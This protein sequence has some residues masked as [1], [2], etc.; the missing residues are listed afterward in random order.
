[1]SSRHRS[2]VPAPPAERAVTYTVT[3]T[4]QHVQPWQSSPQQPSPPQQP[5]SRHSSLE[6]CGRPRV[7]GNDDR[8]QVTRASM[9]LI[10]YV[11]GRVYFVSSEQAAR[12]SASSRATALAA[13][14]HLEYIYVNQEFPYAGYFLDFG[15]LHVGQILAFRRTLQAKLEALEQNDHSHGRVCVLASPSPMHRANAV[16]V[17]ACWGMI[18]YGWSPAEAYAPFAHVLLP[19]FH[20]A[21]LRHDAF[22]LTVLQV[23][24][25]L[26]SAMRH[27]LFVPSG[28]DVDAYQQLASLEQGN[29]S[30]LC[31]KLLAFA[32]PDDSEEDRVASKAS[33]LK[34]PSTSKRRARG[35][36]VYQSSRFYAKRFNELG[37]KTVVRLSKKRYDD[38][39]FEDAGI[40]V[41]DLFFPDGTAPSMA[42]VRRFLS[43]CEQ[44]R[45]GAIA[46]HCKAGLGRT[47]TLI[48]CYL[49]Q[50]YEF[51]AEAAVGW[52]RLCRPGS[53]IGPQQHFLR[54]APEDVEI[55]FVA[56]PLPPVPRPVK[57]IAARKLQAV[58]PATTVAR[59]PLLGKIQPSWSETEWNVI[60]SSETEWNA[61]AT[62]LSAIETENVTIATETAAT[63]IEVI[64]AS[65][66]TAAIEV[67]ATE[68]EIDRLAE[69]AIETEAIENEIVSAVTATEAIETGTEIDP[70]AN[71]A[72]EIA[73][74]TVIV[75]VVTATESLENGPTYDPRLAQKAL[76]QRYRGEDDDESSMRKKQLKDEL[77]LSDDEQGHDEKS[78][79]DSPHK[80]PRRQSS[81]TGS[82][83]RAPR[84]L[85]MLYDKALQ[86]LQVARDSEQRVQ[87]S[88]SKLQLLSKSQT[89]I[90][91]TTMTKK[92]QEKDTVLEEMGAVIKDLEAQL[93]A[94]GV[95]VEAYSM[96]VRAAS[97]V[98]S[99]SESDAIAEIGAM[100][101]DMDRLMDENKQLKASIADRDRAGASNSD[102]SAS[103][104]SNLDNMVSKAKFEAIEADKQKL[105]KQLREAQQKIA[106]LK[107]AA[108]AAEQAT[109]SPPAAPSAP[110]GDSVS[111][112]EL[113]NLKKKVRKRHSL[114]Q[115]TSVIGDDVLRFDQQLAE[116]ERLYKEALESAATTTVTAVN[117]LPPAVD[118]SEELKKLQKKTE[119]KYE[120][121]QKNVAKLENQLEDAVNA[122][123]SASSEASKATQAAAAAVQ[124]KAKK[125]QAELQEKLDEVEAQATALKAQLEQQSKELATKEAA[126]EE[127]NA[128]LKATA[129]AELSKIKEQAKKAILDLKKK[130]E[131]SSKD[132]QNRKKTLQNLQT[133]LHKQKTDFAAL[134]AQIV[135][136]N[137]QL[138][139]MGKQLAEKV[140]QR[141]QK[142]A[143]AMAGVIENYKREMKERKRL[144]NQV[145]ELKGNIRVLCRVRPISK[146]EISHGSKQ[147]CKF[148]GTEEISLAGEKGKLKTW[149]FDRVFDM[150]STQ[151]QV[152][153][154]VK[155]LV[156]SILDGYSV[157]IFAYGQTGSGKTFTMS[158][159][160]E[161]PGINTRS[162]QELFERK[163]QRSKEYQDDITVSI[164]EIYNEMIRDLLSADAA[165]TN[166]QVRQ[167]PTG[168]F[169]PGLTLIGVQTLDEVF[170]LIKKGN[171]NR[172]T[173]S[174]DMNEHSSRSHSIL[175]INLKSTNLVTSSVASGKLF[176]VDLAGSERLSKTGAEGQRLKEAQNINKSLSA[177]GDV[178]AARASKA[179]HVPYRNSS[180]TYLLQDALGGDS[181]TLMVACAS[182]VDYNSEESYCTLNF[183]SRARSVEM[184]KATKNVSQAAPAKE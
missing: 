25:G 86:E 67:S 77:G 11:P 137:Q 42:I 52:L 167:G 152:F 117:D 151:E 43:V 91:K 17:L 100:K 116:T 57:G 119:K 32:S 79:E 36:R 7:A 110:S 129:E 178:I 138:P 98:T 30:W 113:R 22:G 78:D 147:V 28:F 125:A 72:T 128:K 139:I 19:P 87:D 39:V 143:E 106:S 134:K 58:V 164:M 171:K 93:K 173:H 37:V 154:E 1:M 142:Q 85:Q 155:P 89:A 132:Q 96:P 169:V 26:A 12:V 149:E 112:E 103:S 34:S 181:K 4:V 40:A 83:S 158:G 63:E 172:S 56:S 20:D 6:S 180:L 65:A 122:S 49:M 38:R 9:E 69:S 94:A 148:T 53:V 170:D 61:T 182:P 50:R 84:E 160:P 123:S 136:Q 168:N 135:A 59:V 5:P 121:A 71:A 66:V 92:L 179:K 47:G 27:G 114:A 175:A 162:L 177:L 15:P 2:G 35:T 73:T 64:V 183:A 159:P 133:Q 166:L 176:L 109:P 146:S 23:L 126:W 145:Q 161:N 24:E 82:S 120:A 124:D 60:E 101:A 51:T 163:I 3:P 153:D 141:I 80:T 108:A 45:D 130:L 105:E 184:G 48:A 111:A 70:R 99:A 97:S 104:S 29:L 10:E 90:L 140:T 165:N 33:T 144:F 131:S 46:V 118:N 157:C 62:N 156:T 75:T 14:Q 18:E 150:A 44:A 68:T 107:E 55:G 95:S 21:S 102:S 127:K 76:T 88:L 41:V 31:P 54:P 16:C 174:T 115:L 81:T 74:G 13:A 8:S